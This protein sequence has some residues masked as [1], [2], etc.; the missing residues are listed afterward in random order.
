LAKLKVSID[1]GLLIAHAILVQ[2]A[3]VVSD[4]SSRVYY[5][6]EELDILVNEY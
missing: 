3:L 5:D 1:I 6:D 2:L 4:A